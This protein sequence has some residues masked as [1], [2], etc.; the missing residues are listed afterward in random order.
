VLPDCTRAGQRAPSSRDGHGS[1]HVPRL[2]GRGASGAPPCSTSGLQSRAEHRC[3]P[4]WRRGCRTLRPVARI[5]E[6]DEVAGLVAYLAS[7]EAAF[8]TG[9]AYLVDGGYTAQ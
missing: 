9:A 1:T 4:G 3:P 7:D 6:S 5:G 2:R 8:F